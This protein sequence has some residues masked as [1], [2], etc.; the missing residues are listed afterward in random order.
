VCGAVYN[1]I[2]LTYRAASQ[3]VEVKTLKEIRKT[4]RNTVVEEQL[5]AEEARKVI[6]APKGSK[7]P[8]EI[9]DWLNGMRTL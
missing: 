6:R 1:C 4:E 5:A 3:E 9:A 7:M 2:A 8:G